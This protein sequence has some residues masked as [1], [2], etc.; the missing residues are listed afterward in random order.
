MSYL[1]A[2]ASAVGLARE[3]TAATSWPGSDSRSSVKVRAIAPVPRM[4]HLITSLVMGEAC[5]TR[6]TARFGRNGSRKLSL[7]ESGRS[8]PRSSCE[9][10][11][12]PRM[13]ESEGA[14]GDG[15]R[16]EPERPP[17]RAEGR[18]IG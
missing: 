2:K 3:P 8:P 4:P 9:S 15:E 11:E 1:A 7:A 12:G 6:H 16:A 13:A 5:P 14:P 18:E 10:G 17:A